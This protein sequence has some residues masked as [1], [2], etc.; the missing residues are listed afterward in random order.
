MS[1][2]DFS[3]VGKNLSRRDAWAK[4]TGA[5]QYADDMKLPRMLIG[6]IKRSPLA[7]A[8]ILSIDTKR[9][10]ALPGVKAVLIGKEAPTRYGIMPQLPTELALAATKVRFLGEG[11][12]AVA[13]VDEET[14]LEALELIQVEYAPLP[15]YLTPE[16]SMQEGAALLHRNKRGTN[17]GYEGRQSFGDVD[18]ALANSA[19]VLE[20]SISTSYVNHAFMEPHSALAQFDGHGRLTVWSSTQIPHY[21]QRT[22]SL[23]LDLP[24]QKVRVILPTVGGGFG[25]KGEVAANELC[26]ALLARKAAQPVKVTF[27][28]KEVFYANKGRHPM[29]MKVKVGVDQE[30]LLQA[31]DFDNLMDG[32]AFLGW[33]VVV[34]FYTAAMIH[35]PYQV[36]NVRFRG[37]RIYTN[38][39]TCGAMRGL[40]GVQPRLALETMLDEVAVTMGISPYELKRKNAIESHYTTVSNVYVRHS[41]YKKC[42]DHAVA[43]SG[44][45]E[46]H[47]KL[48]FGKGIGLAGGYYISGTA[49]TLYLAYKPHSSALIRVDSE[50]GVTVYCGAAE[51]GQGS[52]TVLAMIAAEVLG[53]SYEEVQVF[54]GDTG[55]TPFE[56]GS[57]ASR[58]TVG[59]GSA[60]K[61]AAQRINKKLY[62]VAAVALG[63]QAEQLV[64]KG[65]KI[66]STFETEK[67]IGFWEA[68]D[69]YISAYGPL[70]ATGHFTPPR[71]SAKGNVQGGNIGHS[72]TYGFSAQ[73][74]E[75]EVDLETGEIKVLKVTE[76]GD[77]GQ[78]I[79]PLSV[80][81]QVEG[82]IV[83]GMGQALYEEMVVKGDRVINPNLHEYR[84]PTMADIPEMDNEIVES[85]DPE[86]PFG[87]KESGE[88]PIQPVIPAI[89]NAIYDAIGV[90]FTELPVTPERVLAALKAKSDR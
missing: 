66:F 27:E 17:L 47:R 1:K 87:A 33:G 60:V 79:N 28:R 21:L 81:G 45:L 23:V 14:A 89:L 61:E 73:V 48:P 40:G 74:A 2:P 55:S 8:R 9:A 77:C 84:I 13:A 78:A 20:K 16:E 15:F 88:G 70:T 63:I 57:F 49:Y 31:I 38:K 7:H 32:G 42:L 26:A 18:Q 12:A 5:A 62:G 30:G 65:G 25:G 10:E 19:L 90:R 4:V 76:A 6:K 58:V 53:L 3:V 36:A 72:P 51:I 24:M 83:M 86:S 59:S 39:P 11:V 29:H 82:S 64:S 71:R 56:L 54:S 46:K 50:S 22:L 43:R 44:Y 34:L 67:A 75:V 41:E 35:L 69:K 37:R 52:D 80:E 85:Y 68:V